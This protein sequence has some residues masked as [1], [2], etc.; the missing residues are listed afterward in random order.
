MTSLSPEKLLSSY[1]AG[2]VNECKHFISPQSSF[3]AYL[4]YPESRPTTKIT[5]GVSTGD[6]NSDRINWKCPAANFLYCRN[7]CTIL[8]SHWWSEYES[9]ILQVNNVLD[10]SL[11]RWKI[12][13]RNMFACAPT[14]HP[15]I[16]IF[17]EI[18][19]WTMDVCITISQIEHPAH[20]AKLSDAD[21]A[22]LTPMLPCWYGC[23]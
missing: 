6:T 8:W 15:L 21:A 4:W 16:R 1:F 5:W 20:Y 2:S 17:R 9:H 11:K 23:S 19:V 13:N 7:G 22:T 18:Y 3:I 12:T 10:D 14:P